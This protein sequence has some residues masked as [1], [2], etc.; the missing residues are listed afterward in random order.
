VSWHKFRIGQVVEYHPPRGTYAARGPYAVTRLLPEKAG[1]FEYVIR[2]RTR[3]TSAS[4][5]KANWDVC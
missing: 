1:E 5:A 2:A 3:R 4:R